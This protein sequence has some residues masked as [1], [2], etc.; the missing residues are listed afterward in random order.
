MK[1]S[2]F[3]QSLLP[4]YP[5]GTRMPRDDR[6]FRYGHA[7]VALSQWWGCFTYM[8]TTEV[9]VL[10]ENA[11]VGTTVL[12]SI[13]IAAITADKY[14]GGYAVCSQ[15]W[16]MI[17]KIK[18]NTG[19]GAGEAFTITLEEPIW[20]EMSTATSCTL[21]TSLF[22]DVRMVMGHAEYPGFTT[23]VGVPLR[24]FTADYYG[25]FQTWGPCPIMGQGVAGALTSERGMYFWL[26]GSVI[27]QPTEGAGPDFALQYAGDLLP[28][29]G[30][31]GDT[32]DLLH[33]KIFLN[34]KILP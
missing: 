4:K 6:V 23:V 1:Q 33:S 11:P 29:T 16:D 5:V 27:N 28:F 21:Y 20:R 30:P 34:L 18:S 10:T 13:S 8:P 15:P 2:I 17:G 14:K 26:D 31:V 7:G 32:H 9:H 19:C 12:H 25:W 3:E 24:D 22:H